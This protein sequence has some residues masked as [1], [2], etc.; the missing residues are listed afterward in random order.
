[1][2]R[3]EGGEAIDLTQ[4]VALVTGGGRGL[5]R[6]FALA[7]AR[8][9]AKIAVLARSKNQVVETASMVADMGGTALSLSA[10]VTDQVAVEEAVRD[11]ERL[12]GPIDTLVNNAGSSRA[13]GSL[14]EVDPEEWWR[15]IEVNLRGPFLCSRAVLPGMI[16]RG[17]GR[18]INVSS[19]AGLGPRPGYSCYAASKAALICLTDTLA[20]ETKNY[21]IGVFAISPGTVRTSMTEYLLQ[22]D[23]FRQWA[24]W[25]YKLFQEGQD[26]S[27][28]LAEKLVV[29]IASG[30]ADNL[31]GRFISVYDDITQLVERSDEIKQDDLYTLRLRK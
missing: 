28:T 22:T 25:V 29:Y 20:V 4:R 17:H 18:I 8:C 31:S 3:I 14:W 1:M 21:G 30:R 24:P 10:D 19:G 11:T 27:P 26:D 12:I 15:D 6:H 23:E 7:L 13:A 2:N 9:G 16:E 5:G